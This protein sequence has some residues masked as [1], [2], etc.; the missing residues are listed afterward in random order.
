MSLLRFAVLVLSLLAA[1]HTVATHGYSH[2]SPPGAAVVKMQSPD[3]DP[4]D[5]ELHFCAL[6]GVFNGSHGA[7]PT[8][9]AGSFPSVLDAAVT[10]SAV[11]PA[12]TFRL[13]RAFEPR[14]PPLLSA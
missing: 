7:P 3:G 8:A 12:L 13:S 2:V 9:H 6:C 14:A 10:H 11:A 1:Q 5:A 4:L